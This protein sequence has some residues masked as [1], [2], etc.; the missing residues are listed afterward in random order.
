MSRGAS[1]N[2]RRRKP[3]RNETRARFVIQRGG[4]P[5]IPDFLGRS[6]G[7]AGYDA[8]ARFVHVTQCSVCQ[9]PSCST[10]G[11]S[12]STPGWLRAIAASRCGGVPTTICTRSRAAFDSAVA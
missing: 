11:M 8:L 2:T 4:L 6:S 10:R 12:R 3:N 1:S 9:W 5:A 7:I